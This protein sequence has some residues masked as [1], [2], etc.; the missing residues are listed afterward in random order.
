MKTLIIRTFILM[1]LSMAAI[2]APQPRVLNY[3][4]RISVGNVNFNGSGQFKFAIVNATGTQTYWSNDGTSANGSQPTSAV[5]LSV[6]NGLY[7]VPLGDA[8]LPNMTEVPAAIFANPDVRLGVWFNDGSPNGSQLLTPDQ[9][10]ASVG[11]AFMARTVEDGAITGAQIANGSIGSAQLAS[12]LTLGGTTSGAFSGDG[13]RLTGLPAS[14]LT[15]VLTVDAGRLA[16]LGN[17]SQSQMSVFGEAEEVAVAG[18][19]AYLA[20]FSDGL[21][22]IDISNPEAPA[23]RGHVPE[24]MMGGVAFGVAVSGSYAYLAN[25]NGG[26]RII[27]ISNPQ[28]PAL[29]GHYA[30]PAQDGMS[31]ANGVAVSGQ[32]FLP[33]QW[34][35]RPAHH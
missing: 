19:Y 30:Q 29:T 33:R 22:I 1:L 31:I 15:G 17:I 11:H 25:S 34:A 4:G 35:G 23:L 2:A 9:R 3:Q 28:A 13:S 32:L 10:L 5:S 12:G 16:P 21:R 18:G 20:N 27:N 8:T 6:T 24:S 26:L 14:S 7:S